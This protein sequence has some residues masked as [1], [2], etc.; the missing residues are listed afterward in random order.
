MSYK[1]PRSVALETTGSYSKLKQ[2]FFS[3]KT[4]ASESL[5]E[6]WGILWGSFQTLLK[7]YEVKHLMTSTRWQLPHAYTPSTAAESSY[8]YMVQLQSYPDEPNKSIQMEYVRAGDDRARIIKK[9]ARE[10]GMNQYFKS[11]PL[12]SSIYTD[13][14]DDIRIHT[15]H[16]PTYYQYEYNSIEKD[17]QDFKRLLY[18]VHIP[19]ITT[20][21]LPYPVLVVN[22]GVDVPVVIV[23]YQMFANA[24]YD[25]V[26][27]LVFDY[28]LSSFTQPP[29]QTQQ[30]FIEKL[31]ELI[32]NINECISM[33]VLRDRAASNLSQLSDTVM[34]TDDIK[35]VRFGSSAI[36]A[37]VQSYFAI[38]VPTSTSSVQLYDL[39]GTIFMADDSQPFHAIGVSQRVNPFLGIQYVNVVNPMDYFKFH[40]PICLI[41]EVEQMVTCMKDVDVPTYYSS[42]VKYLLNLVTQQIPI[43]SYALSSTPSTTVNPVSLMAPIS[44]CFLIED[45][46]KAGCAQLCRSN[47]N[48]FVYV[49]LKTRA[50]LTTKATMVFSVL[51]SVAS[52]SPFSRK[53]IHSIQSYLDVQ[54]EELQMLVQLFKCQYPSLVAKCVRCIVSASS[55]DLLIARNFM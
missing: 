46:V 40:L 18:T 6:H 2:S 38:V 51:L 43:S 9:K 50:M 44:Y 11:I 12:K 54:M 42:R 39:L 37:L 52:N 36:A 10:Y 24:L 33:V 49:M 1:I 31:D 26:N 8:V 5:L 4:L 16:I 23:D 32:A 45:L 7:D 34:A 48:L 35:G 27:M 17:Q 41:N 19:I 14:P 13:K 15:T 47:V 22:I 29:E 30:T 20:A 25:A 28:Q 53:L 55:N 21:S 3:V